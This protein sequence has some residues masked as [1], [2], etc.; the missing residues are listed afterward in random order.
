MTENEI[1]LLEIIRN[2]P[3]PEQ[4]LLIAIDIICKHLEQFESRQ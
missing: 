2:H 4:A 3:N 1:K